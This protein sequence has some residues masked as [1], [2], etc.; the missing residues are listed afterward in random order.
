MDAKEIKN[1][2]RKL[3]AFLKQFN[4]C[5][6]RSQPRQLIIFLLVPL[7]LC[8]SMSQ[9]LRGYIFLRNPRLNIIEFS[10]HKFLPFFVDFCLKFGI[11]QTAI[12][13]ADIQRRTARLRISRYT[14]KII[15]R[16][17]GELIMATETQNHANRLSS[18]AFNHL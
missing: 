17:L 7:C 6:C 15:N 5:F 14:P 11:I 8:P 1:L 13:M 4:D 3:N 12:E 10:V 9:C 18:P 16:K 2:G